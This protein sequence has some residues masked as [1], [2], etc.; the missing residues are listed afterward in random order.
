MFTN[1]AY[2]SNL[3]IF[4][5]DNFQQET[6]PT[7]H[8]KDVYD[9]KVSDKTYRYVNVMLYQCTYTV[10]NFGNLY[11]TILCILCFII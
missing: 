3:I 8:F 9:D 4:K 11:N 7:C 6:Y 1:P 5:T 2:L 10:N